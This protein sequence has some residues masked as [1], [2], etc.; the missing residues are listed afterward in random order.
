VG[1]GCALTG[2]RQRLGARLPRRRMAGAKRARRLTWPRCSR[3]NDPS[4]N[5][6]P[7]GAVAIWWDPNGRT[8]GRQL[9]PRCK[10]SRKR[11]RSDSFAGP[12]GWNTK[13]S[14]RITCRANLKSHSVLVR[15]LERSI[16]N[17]C[18]CRPSTRPDRPN[19]HLGSRGRSPARRSDWFGACVIPALQPARLSCQLATPISRNGRIIAAKT[20]AAALTGAAIWGANP[21]VS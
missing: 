18:G 4:A 11:V 19:A 15:Q 6:A 10:I 3:G 13:K 1:H 17:A 7:C 2:K 20:H 8:R 16:S 14:V 9:T 5:R 21:G 12:F